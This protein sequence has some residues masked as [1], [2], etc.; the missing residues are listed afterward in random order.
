MRE[1]VEPNPCTHGPDFI[2]S[3]VAR[4]E[5]RATG[6]LTGAGDDLAWAVIDLNRHPLEIWGRRTRWPGSYARTAYDLDAALVTNGP[7]VGKRLSPRRKLTR[8][9]ILAELALHSA[10]GATGALVTALLTRRSRRMVPLIAAL[11]S[12]VGAGTAAVR[13]FTGWIPC[14]TVRGEAAAIAD[15][16]DFDGEGAGHAWFGRRAGTGFAAYGVGDGDLPAAIVEGMGGLILLI[17]DHQLVGRTV[18]DHH[19]RRDFAELGDKSGCVAWGLVPLDD[20]PH[21][22][23]LTVIGSGSR[24]AESCARVLAAIGTR[25][26]VATDQ[27]GS[28]LMCSGRSWLLRPPSVPRQSMQTYGLC[29]R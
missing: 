16:R 27:R 3:A 17:K 28:V 5:F 11:G 26:A 29:C 1:A 19:F 24:T 6:L 21:D 8:S 14:G 10:A 7:M 13:C 25:D 12:T 18:T 20:Q 9:S 22:G 23:V 4:A 2:R 15:P